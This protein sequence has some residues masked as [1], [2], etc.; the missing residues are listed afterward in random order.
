[1]NSASVDIATFL[2]QETSLVRA[3]SLF[4]GKEPAS[5][6]NAVTLFD[7]PGGAT[8]IRLEGGVAKYYEYPSVSVRIRAI[9]YRDGWAVAQEVK[10]VLHGLTGLVINGTCYDSVVC[11]QGPF[12]LDWD[13][14]EHPR[15]VATFHITRKE[16]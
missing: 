2:E 3:I 14:H 16:E 12:L 10:R 13:E 11:V 8:E 7:T 4:V 1:M 15:F 9:S 6:V 5:P